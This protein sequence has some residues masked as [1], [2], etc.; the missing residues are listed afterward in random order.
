MQQVLDTG[1]HRH[2]PGGRV[3]PDWRRI[4]L[5]RDVGVEDLAPDRRTE[6]AGLPWPRHDPRQAQGDPVQLAAARPVGQRR[7]G[8]QLV[9]AVGQGRARREVVVDGRREHRSQ[10]GDRADIDDA[11]RALRLRQSVEQGEG[12]V[13]V[14]RARQ[15]GITFRRGAGNGRHVDDQARQ[16]RQRLVQPLRQIALDATRR[17]RRLAEI[18]VGQGQRPLGERRMV[19]QAPG[20]GPP[21][22]AARAGDQDPLIVQ[23]C[24]LASAPHAPLAYRRRPAKAM[25]HK[26]RLASGGSRPMS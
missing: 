1:P 7:L 18:D 11:D 3:R 22:E 6:A 10:G 25:P 21:D 23:P 15:L 14:H 12:N 17:R 19:Q 24:P 16:R 9:R 2:Q 4:G 13:E 8:H 5:T 20:Q 26:R